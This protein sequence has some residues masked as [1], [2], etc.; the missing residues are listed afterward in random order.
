MS[1]NSKA[2]AY[3]REH[4]ALYR[5]YH[6]DEVQWQVNK[7][8]G[9]NLTAEETKAVVQKIRDERGMGGIADY[10]MPGYRAQNE[11]N[12]LPEGDTSSLW[13]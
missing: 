10:N 7:W 8:S 13:W 5:H 3:I 2:E 9:A 12:E 1:G 4:T 11:E 6:I